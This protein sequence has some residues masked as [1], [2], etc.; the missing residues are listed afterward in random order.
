M[1]YFAHNQHNKYLPEERILVAPDIGEGES[2]HVRHSWDLRPLVL[3]VVPPDESY[4]HFHDVDVFVVTVVTC[5]RE[6]K[7]C[8]D[9]SF[10]CVAQ[11]VLV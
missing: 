2:S 4:K 1:D 9:V 11:H 5:H 8:L 3:S 7:V 10:D 6:E